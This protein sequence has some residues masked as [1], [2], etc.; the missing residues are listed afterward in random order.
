[1]EEKTKFIVINGKNVFVDEFP[2]P[3]RTE[4]EFFDSIKEDLRKVEKQLKILVLAAS[5]QSAKISQLV[6]QIGNTA[7]P[8]QEEKVSENG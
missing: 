4:I 3:I 6:E 8:S 1:M 7:P 5:A 2:K